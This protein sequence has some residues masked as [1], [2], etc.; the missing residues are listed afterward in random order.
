MHEMTPEMMKAIMMGDS[1]IADALK[2]AQIEM[3]KSQKENLDKL[4][5]ER[6]IK[7]KD[8]TMLSTKE[9]AH[10]IACMVEIAEERKKGNLKEK[11][12]YLTIEEKILKMKNKLQ[13]MFNIV[14]QTP[15]EAIPM[16]EK[17]AKKHE[18][19]DKK[20]KSYIG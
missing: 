4:I 3:E 20:T 6:I 19:E 12:V 11:V 5:K 8:K 9:M 10:F 15:E 1:T 2:R 14:I 16:M 7:P 13:K 18:E 17:M